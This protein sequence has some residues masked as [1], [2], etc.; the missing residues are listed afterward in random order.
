VLISLG[1]QQQQQQQQQTSMRDSQHHDGN[2]RANTSG[3]AM[4]AQADACDSAP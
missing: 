3:S 2:A 4:Q 1:R